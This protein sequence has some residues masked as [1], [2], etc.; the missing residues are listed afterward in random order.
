MTTAT[1]KRQSGYD[2]AVPIP[3]VRDEYL[4]GWDGLTE[5][6]LLAEAT[7]PGARRLA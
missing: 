7:R 2:V 1:K 6:Q 5:E 4:D 3:P